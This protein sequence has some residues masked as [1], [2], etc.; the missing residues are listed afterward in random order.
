[1]PYCKACAQHLIRACGNRIGTKR[2]CFPVII[3]VLRI[4]IIAISSPAA[5]PAWNYIK[6]AVQRVNHI[7]SK[8]IHIPWNRITCIPNIQL[9]ILRRNRRCARFIGKTAPHTHCP[10]AFLY[11][12]NHVCGKLTELLSSFLSFRSMIFIRTN[13]YNGF[14]IKHRVAACKIVFPKALCKFCCF[15]IT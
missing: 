6:R 10:S 3:Q 8:I 11:K 13:M 4:Q 5:C 12:V 9:N 15:R 7:V 2:V 14:L 1:M